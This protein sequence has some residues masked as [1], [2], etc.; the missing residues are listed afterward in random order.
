MSITYYLVEKI[1]QSKHKEYY[2]INKKIVK[3]TIAFLITYGCGFISFFKISNLFRGILL[4]V[5]ITSLIYFFY[6]Q[7]KLSK[8]IP[9][10]RKTSPQELIIDIKESL[11]KE[12][13][14][15]SI[16]VIELLQEEISKNLEKEELEQKNLFKR[17]SVVF[18][19]I[20]WA[21]IVFL[22]KNF[23]EQHHYKLVWEDYKFISST[24]LTIALQLIGLI[25]VGNA[26]EN[27]IFSTKKKLLLTNRYL[28]DVKYLYTQE[29]SV[30]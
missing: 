3:L 23:I 15:K 25:I 26:F 5:S 8:E 20:F 6:T 17:I 21:P 19:S 7:K 24:L 12:T 1:I 13:Y 4:L 11:R 10:K 22:S 2:K 27:T 14:V 18:F 29:E 30:K 28:N 16:K 9:Q